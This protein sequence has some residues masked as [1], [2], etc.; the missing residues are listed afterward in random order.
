MNTANLLFV[1]LSFLGGL[2]IGGVL[3]GLWFRLHDAVKYQEYKIKIA[4]LQKDNEALLEKM[5]W[6]NKALEKMSETFD[7]LASRSLQSNSDELIKRS[8]EQMATV[9]TPLKESLAQ[10]NTHVREL[11]KE[12]EGAYQ[13]L[14]EKIE[15]LHQSYL[16]LQSS[17]ST[18][19]S[20][21]KSPVARGR[22]GELQLRRVVE[23]AGMVEHV[24][25]DEQI[26]AGGIR[27]DMI[28]YLPNK[29]R[30]PVDAKVPLD[31]YLRSIEADSESERQKFLK[32]HAKAIKQRVKDLGQ[33]QYW[34]HFDE[35]PDLVIMFVPNESFLAAGF[36]YDA[37]IYEFAMKQRVLIATPVTLLALLK[38]V[39]Y[40]W[41]QVQMAEN[42]KKIAQ[43]GKELYSRFG[44]FIEHL[45]S[46]RK[47]LSDAVESY[48]K[49]IGSWDH[50][51]IPAIRRLKELGVDTGQEVTEISAIDEHPQL[52][53]NE[54]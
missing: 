21:L 13:G 6:E 46:L 25:F 17:T 22:W 10:L 31:A 24:D 38:A 40:G 1:S 44:A 39:T 45:I 20:A 18:L 35:T 37:D 32:Q 30:L 19:A 16:Q 51:I 50:R 26:E 2:A 53:I 29:G 8:Q 52:P 27:P 41:Q 3:V 14:K 7:A 12:R 5:E 47:N 54:I 4:E 42:A 34:K 33:K 11:E 23:L 15:Q 28:V 48:N 49:T 43:Q 9:I 36:E